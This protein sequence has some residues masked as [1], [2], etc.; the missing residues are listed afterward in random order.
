M[1]ERG[2]YISLAA[3]AILISVA[4]VLVASF[5]TEDPDDGGRGGAL[6]VA[7]S[8]LVFFI[9]RDLGKRVVP[10]LGER[11][12]T[13]RDIL[14]GDKEKTVHAGEFPPD[15]PIAALQK[16]ID[17]LEAVANIRVAQ[18]RDQSYALAF[19]SVFGTVFWG[20]GDTFSRWLM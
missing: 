14:Q 18:G 11:G 4:G 10:W 13:L 2:R 20:F 7:V 17:C 15:D 6:T 8:F 16:R 5:V 19:T 1:T 3:G 12:R 9:S